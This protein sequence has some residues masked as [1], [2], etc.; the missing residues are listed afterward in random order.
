M[1]TAMPS[2]KMRL[3]QEEQ[4]ETNDQKI[5]RLEQEVI[6]NFHSHLRMKFF[7]LSVM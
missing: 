7:L 3:E 1:P 6:I 2:K 5:L 4:E